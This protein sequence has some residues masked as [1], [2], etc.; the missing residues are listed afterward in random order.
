MMHL[1]SNTLRPLKGELMTE[2][3]IAE[4]LPYKE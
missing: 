4:I 1:F 2:K 3:I